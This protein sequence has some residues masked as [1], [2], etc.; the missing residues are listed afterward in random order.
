MGQYYEQTE[1]VLAQVT[2]T[3]RLFAESKEKAKEMFDEG[4]WEVRREEIGDIHSTLSSD[5]HLWKG[6]S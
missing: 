5:I 6:K 3:T 4:E 2:I 1:V